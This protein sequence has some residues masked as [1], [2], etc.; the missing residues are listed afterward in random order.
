MWLMLLVKPTITI[1]GF[2][3]ILVL[4]DNNSDNTNWADKNLNSDMENRGSGVFKI[5]N[6]TESE[7]AKHSI[8]CFMLRFK[9][10]FLN[11]C[12]Y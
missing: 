2:K 1:T 3:L 12:F 4:N 9:I 8:L 6:Y 5:H 7:M 10:F 11:T